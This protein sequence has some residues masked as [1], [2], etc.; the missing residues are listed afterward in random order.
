M[1]SKAKNIVLL[2]TVEKFD[3]ANPVCKCS[4]LELCKT[5]TKKSSPDMS[6]FYVILAGHDIVTDADRATMC[7]RKSRA[8]P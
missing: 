3:L 8:A 1:K 5:G 7:R 6:N 4:S 2:I